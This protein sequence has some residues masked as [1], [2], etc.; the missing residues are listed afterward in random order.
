MLS[1][2]EH[3][4][5]SLRMSTE[6]TTVDSVVEVNEGHR[7]QPYLATAGAQRVLQDE[8]CEL[9]TRRDSIIM[10]C[11]WSVLFRRERI[12]VLVIQDLGTID[13]DTGPSVLDDFVP[14]PSLGTNHPNSCLTE[15]GF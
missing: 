1:R 6:A 3:K 7:S 2:N 10:G 11:V 9:Y 12:I 4:H 15:L 5:G 8:R 14:S 13:G